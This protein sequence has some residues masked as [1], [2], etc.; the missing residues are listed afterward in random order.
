M[1]DG[2]L[3]YGVTLVKTAHGFGAAER[4]ATFRAVFKTGYEQDEA[5]RRAFRILERDRP[6]ENLMAWKP[7]DEEYAHE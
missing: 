7:L 2:P 6:S 3:V 5:V 4:G 1:A